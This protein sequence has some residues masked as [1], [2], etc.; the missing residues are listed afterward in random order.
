[1]SRVKQARVEQGDSLRTIAARE[2]G[3]PLRWTELIGLN[4]LTLPFVVPSARAD[5][6]LPNT[7][8]WGDVV[9]VPWDSNAR[10]A[11]TPTTNLGIDLDLTGGALQ[12]RNGDLGVVAARDNLI[13]ALRHRVMTLRNELVHDPAYGCSVRLALGLANGPFLEVLGA[14]WVYEALREEPRVAVIDAVTASSSGD[15]LV[16]SARVTLVGDNTPVDLNLVLNP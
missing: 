12:G 6:R 11:P 2:L 14:A 8:I 10:A 15:A 1:M 16:V 5:D 9:L 7:L 13:Q 4:D 3:N